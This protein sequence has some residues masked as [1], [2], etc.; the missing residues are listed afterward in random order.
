MILAFDFKY[1]SNV[2][3][4]LTLLH[5]TSNSFFESSS[6]PCILAFISLTFSCNTST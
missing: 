3:V 2:A 6:E 4:V 1:V 5:K